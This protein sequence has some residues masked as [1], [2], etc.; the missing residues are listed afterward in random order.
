M[1]TRE[2][3]RAIDLTDD[4]WLLDLAGDFRRWG[5][6]LTAKRLERIVLDMR[7]AKPV[8]DH[9]KA[10]RHY[11][12]G[13]ATGSSQ[14][15]PRRRGRPR[16]ERDSEGHRIDRSSDEQHSAPPAAP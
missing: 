14:T 8:T 11:V 2:I 12:K 1:P 6:E 7:A 13:L 10:K 5:N 16:A 3:V 15:L 4:E 9:Q